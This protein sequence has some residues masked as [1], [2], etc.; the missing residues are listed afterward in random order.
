MKEIKNW[1]PKLQVFLLELRYEIV[2]I[3]KSYPFLV[4]DF[5]D[6]LIIRA[7]GS[8]GPRYMRPMAG[9]AKPKLIECEE[10]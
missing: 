9:V 8:P 3:L 2:K 6:L 5:S 4:V 1:N 7:I 10:A